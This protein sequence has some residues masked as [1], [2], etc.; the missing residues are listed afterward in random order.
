ML[1]YPLSYAHINV[2]ELRAVL[3]AIKW[4]TRLPSEIGL[5]C[6]HVVDSQV[7]LLSLAK[8]RS[9]SSRLCYVLRRINALQLAAGLQVLWAYVHTA[10]NPADRPSRWVRK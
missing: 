6:V 3:A 2:Q 5:R 7:S 1:S 9:S 10:D 8:G 4:R